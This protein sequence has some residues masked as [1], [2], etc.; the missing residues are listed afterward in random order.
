MDA[1]KV[2]LFKEDL[3]GSKNIWYTM[4]YFSNNFVLKCKIKRY[5]LIISRNIQPYL[6]QVELSLRYV[7]QDEIKL[8]VE[9]YTQN[10]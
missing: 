8:L 9:Y 10:G 4:R 6:N 7:L 3:G 2:P 5:Y 1:V